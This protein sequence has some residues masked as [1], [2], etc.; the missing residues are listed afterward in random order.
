MIARTGL[1]LHGDVAGMP[2]LCAEALARNCRCMLTRRRSLLGGCTLYRRA[3]ELGR[4]SAPNAAPAQKRPS[5]PWSV[6]RRSFPRSWW[7]GAKS[8]FDKSV[9]FRSWRPRAW[10]TGPARRLCHHCGV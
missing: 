5:T 8:P 9:S 10:F 6:D 2:W 7:R 4:R 3:R 1:L